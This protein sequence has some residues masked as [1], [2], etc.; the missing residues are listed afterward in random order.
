MRTCR[1]RHPV[2]NWFGLRA[3]R[4]LLP[5]FLRLHL[6]PFSD[7][8]LGVAKGIHLLTPGTHILLEERRL[9]CLHCPQKAHFYLHMILKWCSKPGCDRKTPVIYLHFNHILG[10][11]YQEFQRF[12]FLQFCYLSIFEKKKKK[13]KYGFICFVFPGLS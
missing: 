8:F 2:Q 10:Q 1:W 5:P 11:W 4:M 3:R 9:V 7:L 6:P 13:K 12:F